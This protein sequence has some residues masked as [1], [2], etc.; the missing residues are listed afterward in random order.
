LRGKAE[1]RD[2]VDDA[3]VDGL[4]AGAGFFVD[5]GGGDAEDLAGGEG[6]DVFAGSLLTSASCLQRR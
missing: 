2:A 5:V 1:G 6:V 3:E 4:G